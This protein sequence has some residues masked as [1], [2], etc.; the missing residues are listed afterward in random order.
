MAVTHGRVSVRPARCHVPEDRA[1]GSFEMSQTGSR[2]AALVCSLGRLLDVLWATLMWHW[3][4]S[5][6]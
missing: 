5:S 1:R 2:S 6:S 3:D 4:G